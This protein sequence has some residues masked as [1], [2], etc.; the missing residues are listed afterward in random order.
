MQG[1]VSVRKVTQQHDRGHGWQQLSVWM[2]T[3]LV[4]LSVIASG[5]AAEA[6]VRYAKPAATGAGTCGSWDNACTLQTALT[7]AVNGDEIWVM[8]GT[9]TPTTGTDRAATFQLRNGVAVYGGFDGLETAR[10]ERDPA[11]N[12]VILSGDIGTVGDASDNCYHV[13]TGATGATLDGV[14]ISGGNANGSSP[15]NF[16]GGIY[17]DFCSPTV[18]NV[19]FSGNTASD[20]G[21]M[22]N[23]YSSPTLTNVTFRD[24]SVGFYGGV[25]GGM[26]NNY[27]SP[28]L[29]NVTFSG[30]IA[31]TAAGMYNINSS[32]PILTN[33]T[34]S[35]N[36]ANGGGGGMYNNNYSSP[37][38]TNVT[39]SGN[40][41]SG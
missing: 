19:I 30:N 18:T 37:T 10:A 32:N 11:A 29:T 31:A 12:V 28:T 41:V 40:T 3:G 25:G 15:N 24:N 39:F 17:D 23:Y 16:G 33:V 7:G 14:T 6:A 36:S 20:G 9:H 26:Y 21:G 34:F 2:A 22:Y 1:I 5:G 35:S 38:L 13:V 4:V 27:S 8:Q